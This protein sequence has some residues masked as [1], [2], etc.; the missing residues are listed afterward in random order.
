MIR[1]FI[2]SSVLVSACL[3]SRGASR[4]IMLAGLH[5]QVTLVLS[6]IVLLETERNLARLAKYATE[7]LAVFQQLVET[8][9]LTIVTADE[10]A[11]REAASYTHPKDAAIIAAARQ[12]HVDYLVSLDRRHLVDVPGVSTRSGL[13]IVLPEILLA[14]IRE[15]GAD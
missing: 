13:V 1:A 15:G 9:P 6:D 10:A 12:A 14:K 3:S 7:A 5:S 8:V 11:V 4:A 2:D